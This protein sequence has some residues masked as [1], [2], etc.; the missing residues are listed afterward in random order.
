MHHILTWRHFEHYDAWYRQPPHR[1]RASNVCLSYRH[2][3]YNCAKNNESSASLWQST[4]EKVAKTDQVQVEHLQNCTRK[5]LSKIVREFQES[6]LFNSQLFNYRVYE[7]ASCEPSRPC[8]GIWS[9]SRVNCEGVDYFTYMMDPGSPLPKE[10]WGSIHAT[11][12]V[13]RVCA[14]PAPAPYQRSLGFF[15][16]RINFLEGAGSG[17]DTNICLFKTLPGHA[18]CGW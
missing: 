1:Y 11:P 9:C 13:P 7:D 17:F 15:S 8:G 6:P 5:I 18:W 4:V 3:L 2:H 16:R 12:D 10:I 14:I